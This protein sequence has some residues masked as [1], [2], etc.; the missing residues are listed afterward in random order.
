M[1]RTWAADAA[2]LNLS[3]RPGSTLERPPF[4]LPAPSAAHGVPKPPHAGPVS[5]APLPHQGAA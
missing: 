3:G 2:G 1:K 4:L 5:G